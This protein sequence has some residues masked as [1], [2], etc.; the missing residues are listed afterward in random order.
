MAKTVTSASMMAVKIVEAQI[1]RSPSA[2]ICTID[3]TEARIDTIPN[4]VMMMITVS[5]RAR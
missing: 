4:R 1:S 3:N 2:R 5:L